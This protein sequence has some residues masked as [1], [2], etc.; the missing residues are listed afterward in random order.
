MPK[1]MM[2]INGKF[3]LFFLLDLLISKGFKD[4]ILCTGHGHKIIKK[5][6]GDRYRSI[7]ISYSKEENAL[8][9]G[10]AILQALNLFNDQKFFVL[11]GDSYCD[12]DAD[13]QVLSNNSINY[14]FIY[15]V[16]NVSRYGEVKIN[17]VD[18]S[19]SSFIEKKPTSR[20]GFINSGIYIFDRYVFKNFNKGKF[21]S[22][23]SEI[24]PNLV[25]NLKFIL[26]NNIYI[27][28]KDSNH[29]LF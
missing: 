16:S 5:L 8:G 1:C 4:I 7:Q 17:E 21:I 10:G 27:I 6:V 24:L 14:I 13:L 12:F 28:Q 20:G 11:N 22:L 26:C 3:F 19:V 25:G 23:E 15:N 29:T 18:N 2:K 9:T